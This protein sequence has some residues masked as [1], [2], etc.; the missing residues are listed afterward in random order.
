MFH[1]LFTNSYSFVGFRVVVL[2]SL[3]ALSSLLFLA[4][5]VPGLGISWKC[6]RIWENQDKHAKLKKLSDIHSCIDRVATY[7]LIQY[8]AN[9]VLFT[10]DTALQNANVHCPENAFKD[11]TTILKENP[12]TTSSIKS[13]ISYV[14][15][16][17]KRGHRAKTSIFR[18][19]KKKNTRERK[20]TKMPFFSHQ[21]TWTTALPCGSF[22][23]P[24]EQD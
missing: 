8:K 4:H 14:M 17:T 1:S 22:L 12:H 3:S 18:N 19:R 5:K 7:I 15:C 16:F 11:Y 2:L 20:N 10:S 6:D 24:L 21:R 9:Q 23:S 13:R